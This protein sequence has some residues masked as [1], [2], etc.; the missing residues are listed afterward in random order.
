MIFSAAQPRFLLS[1]GSNLHDV[2]VEIS[3]LLLLIFNFLSQTL[4]RL[5]NADKV[6]LIVAW[7]TPF[8]VVLAL[9]KRDVHVSKE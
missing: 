4:I 8:F 2:V 3:V 1:F 5:D 6:R 9:S 7:E